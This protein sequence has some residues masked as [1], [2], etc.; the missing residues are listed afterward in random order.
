M[1]PAALLAFSAKSAAAGEALWQATVR[2]DGGTSIA[3]AITDP[4]GTPSLIPGGEIEQG[5]LIV[6]VRKAVLPERPA[7]QRPLQWK[8]PTETA[9]RPEKW[10]IAEVTG[11]ECDAVW[12]IKCEPWN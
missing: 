11:N 3:A 2:L 8:R 1:D 7:L 12:I 5:E 10:R 4:R 9:W 6:R